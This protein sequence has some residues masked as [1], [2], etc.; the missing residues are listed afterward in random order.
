MVFTHNHDLPRNGAGLLCVATFFFDIQPTSAWYWRWSLTQPTRCGTCTQV[1]RG[2]P[3][4]LDILMT[5]VSPGGPLA[6]PEDTDPCLASALHAKP[7]SMR[8]RLHCFGH[9]HETFGV[10]V[11]PSADAVAAGLDS[12]TVCM[13]AAQGDILAADR[14]GG[15][16][17]L[18][19]VV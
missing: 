4:G 3:D 16:A 19:C 13:N 11:N 1:F 10:C 6:A 18:V 9:A 14:D 5:H 15:G 12:W 8:P 2:I 17:P 7:P